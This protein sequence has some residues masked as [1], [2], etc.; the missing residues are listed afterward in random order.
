V[1][2]EPAKAA[3]FARVSTTDQHTENQ[4]LAEWAAR[5]G[6]QVVAEFTVHDSAWRNGNGKGREFD[7]ARAQLLE[8]ARRGDYRVVLI[9][10]LDRWTRRGI[11]DAITTLEA[12]WDLGVDVWSQQ[13][14][15]VEAPTEIRPLM[16]SMFA[17]MGAMESKRRSERTKAGLQRRKE[18]DGKPVGRQPG[19]ADKK[20]RRRSGYVSAW[21][22]E[23]GERRRAALAARNR[24]RAKSGTSD[25]DS[26]A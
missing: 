21:E 12:L 17:W 19:A 15:F 18:V 26:G 10:A 3:I 5:R 4:G 13:E 22:G 16:I 9:W 6:V 7:Q 14:P 2:G 1:T 25:R 11:R 24:A 20:P 8:G 23:A